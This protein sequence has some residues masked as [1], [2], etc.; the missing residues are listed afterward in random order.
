MDHA[1]HDLNQI[2]DGPSDGTWTTMTPQPSGRQ[3]FAPGRQRGVTIRG[4]S[5]ALL[6]GGDT[7]ARW[8]QLRFK[9][10]QLRLPAATAVR[11]G[12]RRL[13]T[14]ERDESAMQENAAS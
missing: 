13:F 11:S 8:Q 5:S 3:Q 7:I 12:E 14:V 9:I 4:F 6:W 2:A 1:A 10:L